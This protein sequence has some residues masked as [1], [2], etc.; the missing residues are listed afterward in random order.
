M[1]KYSEFS[2]ILQTMWPEGPPGRVAVGVS[3]GA[4]SLALTWLLHQWAGAQGVNLYALTVDHAIRAESSQEA[5]QVASWMK[6]WGVP[7]QVLVWQHDTL[8]TGIMAQARQARY[9][10]M[11]KACQAL[12]VRHLFVA[13]HRQDQEETQLIRLLGH[14]HL[15]GMGGMMACSSWDQLMLMR[16]L[17]GWNKQEC[18]QL[19]QDIKQSWI[20]DP[21]NTNLNYQRIRLR[22]MQ[23]QKK[24][25][26]LPFEGLHRLGAAL[27][28]WVATTL[29]QIQCPQVR[30]Y[31][32]LDAVPLLEIPAWL[33]E[34]VVCG[35][36]KRLNPQ[37]FPPRQSSL[38]GWQDWFER[39]SNKAHT[40]GGY[41]WRQQKNT[42]LYCRE[43][44]RIPFSNP[45]GTLSEA[46][47]FLY[48]GRHS[49]ALPAGQYGTAVIGPLGPMGWQQLV[50]QQPDL[51]G[52]DVARPVI[53][54]WPALWKN[55][56]VEL[57]YNK[58]ILY[59][60]QIWSPREVLSLR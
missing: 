1:K 8:Q 46:T 28:S 53:Y 41:I 39:C 5:Q 18:R 56:R 33:R 24:L 58:A 27:K 40:L 6:G 32:C 20:E 15:E 31:G 25:P 37:G 54:G 36:L 9:A 16:P 11:Q 45:L 21:S 29:S 10:L 47:S 13:H 55:G 26:D 23:D 17:L 30:G 14:S 60:H 50:Q 42:L 35:L 43:Y 34:Y 57:E 2:H 38:Q 59:D 48:D 3:G 49:F 7:H 12:G 22:W 52:L 4:D 51:K 44:G 19:L